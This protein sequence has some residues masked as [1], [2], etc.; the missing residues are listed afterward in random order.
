MWRVGSRPTTSRGQG[1]LVHRGRRAR[2]RHPAPGRAGLAEG[3]VPLP[4]REDPVLQHPPDRRRPATASAAARAATSSPSCRRSSTSPSPRRSSG[5]PQQA[6]HGAAA[7]RRAARPRDGGV[8]R[9]AVPAH[10]GPPGGRRSST[11]TPLLDTCPRP[12]PG[13]TSCASAAS[14]ARPPSGS[15]SGFAPRGGEALCPPP[16]RQGLHRRRDR[17]RRAV[18]AGQPRALRPVP[19]PAGLADPRHHRR[20]GRLRR[21]PPLR[22]RPDRGEVPQHLRDADLQEVAAC[23]TAST[24]PRR[25]SPRERQAVVVE[26]YTD[27]MAVPPRRRRERGRHLRHGVRRRPHQDAAPH[28]ARRGRPRAGPGDLHLRRRRGRAEGR[29]AGLRRGPALGRPS[30]SSPSRPTGMDPCELRHGQGRRRGAR[31]RRG[32]RA[33]VRVRR[34]HHDQPLR[35]RHRR[36]AG[37]GACG[38]SPRSSRS[39]RDTSAAP[40]V[41]PHRRRL[42]RRRGRAGR[43][44]RSPS[45]G[46]MAA[47]DGQ[48]R[49]RGRRAGHRADTESVPEPRSRRPGPRCRRPTCATP[50][51]SPSGSC[52]RRCSSSP[53][54]SS[55]RRSTPSPPD[56]VRGA[57][58]PGGASTASGSPAASG[59]GL[60]TAAWADKVAEAAPLA[61]RGLGLRAVGGAAADA[62]RQ[63]HRPAERSATSTALLVRVRE[64]AAHPADRRRHVRPCGG[65]PHDPHSDPAEARALSSDLQ[66]LQRELATLRERA[67]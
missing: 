21:P 62:L 45:A 35:P 18:R 26:G 10:R 55:R 64:V 4:R 11:P 17:H 52:C 56:V 2:A 27:V 13:A 49:G 57:R 8:A 12:G 23:S 24:P 61:V 1:A 32:R 44:P 5:S 20:H 19:G 47:R 7:T 42:A 33:D 43:R 41:H 39:I 16:A 63:G 59:T 48:G 6:R 15:A 29:D 31:P 67:S 65:W 9:Q 28:H 53:R 66:N 51:S 50:S 60:S 38:P 46:R 54:A 30:R 34:A 22:R 40:R 14:T 3:P 25:R 37:A 36:G 58:P